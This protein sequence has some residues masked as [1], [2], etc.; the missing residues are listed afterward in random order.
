[1]KI[2][3]NI[4]WLFAV[5]MM[6]ACS[7]DTTEDITDNPDPVNQNTSMTP[8]EVQILQLINNHRNSQDLTTLTHNDDA[9]SIALEHTN[10]MI[11]QGQISHDNFSARAENLTQRVSAQ[12]VGENVAFR[13]PTAES[14]VQ[15]W[16]DSSG[17][18][19]NIEGDFT[20]TAIVARKNSDG[21]YYFT[22]L[23][24]R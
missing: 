22:Q 8:F 18:R 21:D 9:Y 12:R 5:F 14:V 24:Y 17:H 15:A 16:L 4:L 1:M 3:K 20:H 19:R 7:S 11:G 2:L 6:L 13:Y 10:Y 23:F